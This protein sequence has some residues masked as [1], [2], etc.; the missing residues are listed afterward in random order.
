M[1]PAV[2]I[3]IPNATLSSTSPPYTIYNITLRLPLRS[4]TVQKRYN[5]FVS[6]HNQLTSQTNASPP[7]ILPSKSWFSRTVNNPDLT[8]SRRQG[9]ETYLRTINTCPDAKWRSTSAWRTFLNLPSSSVSSS[10]K[11]S[12]LHSTLTGPAGAGAPIT[13][14]TVWLDCHR[15]LKTQ[16]HDARLQLTNRDQASTP[17]K[18]HESSANAKASLVKAGSMITALEKGLES[19]SQGENGGWGSKSLGEG[20]MRRRKDLIA[21]ARKEKEGLENLL[22]AM[23]TKSK[24]DQTVAS[25]QDKSALVGTGKPK[26]GRVLGKETKETRE[27]DNE[28]V[29]QLQKQKMQDQ[30]LDVDELRKIIL[31]QKELG[32]AI[33]NELAVQADMLNAVDEDVDRVQGKVDIAKRRIGK[34]S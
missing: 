10:G 15:D 25:I 30:D 9:L 21:N 24:L 28:G 13:D 27:L 7:A 16:L 2:E 3:S 32:I 1:A 8:E 33:N 4:F 17:Q 20:E 31:R 12:A 14:P 6:L 26:S 11:S 29:V 5:D 19:L 22:N 18:Q 34:I 23:A